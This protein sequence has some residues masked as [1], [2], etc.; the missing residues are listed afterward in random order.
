LHATIASLERKRAAWRSYE[1]VDDELA[2][3]SRPC[4]WISLF[5]TPPLVGA[6]EIW[7]AKLLG[8][9]VSSAP[10]ALYCLT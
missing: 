1:L 5:T 4:A 6:E 8:Y 9:A 7:I 10:C 2:P 3:V